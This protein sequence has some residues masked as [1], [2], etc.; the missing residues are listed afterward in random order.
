MNKPWSEASEVAMNVTEQYESF[1]GKE[2]P[3]QR[4]HKWE[5]E[6]GRLLP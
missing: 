3:I 6:N 2:I 1:N 5:L 4:V